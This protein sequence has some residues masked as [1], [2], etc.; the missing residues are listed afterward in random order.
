MDSDAIRVMVVGAHP[1]DA[2]LK[3]GGL[4]AKYAAAGHEVLF[5]SVTNGAAGHHEI[6]GVE[7]ARRRRQ[8][9]KNA[10]SVLGIDYEI[11]DVPDG[12]L[13]PTLERRKRLIRR[14]REYGPDLVLTH[15]PNDYHPDHRYTSVL[16]RDSAYMVT[17]PNVCP[18]TR[19]LRTD[20]V[21]GYLSDGFE[22]PSPF[23]PDVVVSIDDVIETKLEALAEHESQF[24]EWLPYN[25][26]KLE[27]V[28]EGESE[29][30]RWIESEYL[31]RFNDDADRFR[32]HLLERYGEARGT[33]I[34]FAESIE[35]SEYGTPLT[36]ENRER[37]VPFE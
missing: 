2:D 15:R 34:E 3:F 6:G 4:A 30:R 35:G 24:F 23:E 36:G 10:A 18:G 9:A 7:L 25:D 11:W 13:Q 26:R 31:S 37:L 32:E 21:F 5:L 12:E 16:V 22:K 20:P 8:E 1:D 28:P 33:E 14:I 29:R 17:V 27:A 19:A